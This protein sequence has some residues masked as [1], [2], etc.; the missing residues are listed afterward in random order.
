MLDAYCTNM[1]KPSG[2][3]RLTKQLGENVFPALKALVNFCCRRDYRVCAKAIRRLTK[4]GLEQILAS[5]AEVGLNTLLQ[6][7]QVELDPQDR[8][9]DFLSDLSQQDLD[10]LWEEWTHV[11]SFWMKKRELQIRIQKDSES[12][13]SISNEMEVDI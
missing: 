8:L 6:H 9:H 10:S 3:K 2:R 11:H 5:N 12:K 4:G 1:S 13:T 7:Y